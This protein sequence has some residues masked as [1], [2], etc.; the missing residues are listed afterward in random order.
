[1]AM[2][3]EAVWLAC[4]RCG[5]ELRGAVYE[6]RAL[7]DRAARCLRCALMDRPMLVRSFVICLIVGTVLTA[8]NQGNVIL[9]GDLPAALAWKIPLTYSV[10]FSVATAGATLNARSA[11][12][13]VSSQG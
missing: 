12:S 6:T 7:E 5:V 8:I 10:P 11:V 2:T 3:T 4:G 9:G 13:G 1:M